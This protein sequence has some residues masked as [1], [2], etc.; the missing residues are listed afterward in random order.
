MAKRK[1]TAQGIFT[2]K[3]PGKIFAGD[4]NNIRYR[5]SW[6]FSI[7]S[8]LDRNPLC[9]GWAS[10]TCRIPY[11][12]PDT[13]R[14]T[15]YVPDLVVV[16]ADPKTGK[17]RCEMLEIKPAKEVPF[18]MEGLQKLTAKDRAA[19]AINMAKWEAAMAFCKKRGITFRVMTEYQIYPEMRR[20]L[21]MQMRK[22]K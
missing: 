11:Q 4:P 3:N 1:Q 13:G 14:M 21:A 20:K 16:Y 5:S 18:L 9:C 8:A 10:E 19:Q 6:E 22:K 15:V 17:K 7:M 2:P 12:R